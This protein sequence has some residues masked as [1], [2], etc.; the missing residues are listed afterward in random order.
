MPFFFGGSGVVSCLLIYFGLFCVPFD[1]FA[2]IESPRPVSCLCT[3]NVELN[4][5]KQSRQ[6]IKHVCACGEHDKKKTAHQVYTVRRQLVPVRRET[7]VVATR[8]AS[9]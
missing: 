7:A 2:V 9:K 5:A 6:E 1:F 3:I 8:E 4:A